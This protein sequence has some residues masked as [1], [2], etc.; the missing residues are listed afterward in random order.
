MKFFKY[1]GII[2]IMLFSFYYT[3]RIATLVLEKNPL[4]QEIEAS[5]D[6]YTV[7]S[8]AAQ[9]DGDYIIPGLSGQEVNVK[10]SYYNMKNLDTFNEYYL[11][12][13]S[14]L[15]KESITNNK[16]KIIK[17]G[18][19]LKRNIAFI[20]ENDANILNYFNT[21]NI[22]G[23]V[24]VDIDNFEEMTKYNFEF[25][26]NDARNYEKI[27]SLLTNSNLNQNLC[28]LNKNITEVCR[29]YN[30]YL[31]EAVPIDNNSFLVEKNKIANGK[32]YL[33]KKGTNVDNIKL[34]IED[35]KFKDINI[36]PLSELI[37]E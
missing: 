30:K 24:L 26:N 20:L 7:A 33:I 2:A 17:Q 29:K 27:E 23:N 8:V 37:K 4:Y 13:S 6:K 10:D 25:I 12:F 11:V 18:N 19:S 31:I 22:V 15:P 36:V 16:D 34:L 21:H 14:T 5:K 28:L 35:I 32:I 9:I 1:T 3:D